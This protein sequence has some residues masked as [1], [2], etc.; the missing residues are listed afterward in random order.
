MA[1]N[2]RIKLCV[3]IIFPTQDKDN[4]LRGHC[5]A[6]MKSLWIWNT[7]NA[8]RNSFNFTCG[9]CGQNLRISDD[10]QIW[11]YLQLIPVGLIFFSC[12]VLIK[13]YKFP[14]VYTFPPLLVVVLII[15]SLVGRYLLMYD[16]R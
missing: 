14:G 6:C 3:T 9:H 2:S 7:A 13:T 8:Q 1:T 5:P 10:T 4:L 15:S 12:S 11:V 16:K